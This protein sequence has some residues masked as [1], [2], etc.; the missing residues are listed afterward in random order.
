[1]RRALS[2]PGFRT[3]LAIAEE[4]RLPVARQRALLGHIAE[5]TYYKWKSGDLTVLS[6]D[7]LERI[8]LVLGIYKALALI[9]ADRETGHDWLAAANR[10]AIFGGGTPLDLMSEGGIDGLYRVR[11]YLDAWRGVWS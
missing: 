9:F 3:F 6:Y 7:Q 10:E 11:R 2:G 4:W 5:A 1:M 8:S